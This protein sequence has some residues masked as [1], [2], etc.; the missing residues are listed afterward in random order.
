MGPSYHEAFLT[1]M[2]SLRK[3]THTLTLMKYL[4]AKYLFMQ[5]LISDGFKRHLD[6]WTQKF[7]IY[8]ASKGVSDLWDDF[9]EMLNNGAE[10]FKP[11][12]ILKKQHRLPWVSNNIKRL[13]RQR[14]KAFSTMKDS[15]TQENIDK[16]KYLKSTV[17]REI[18]K[19]YN[20]YIEDLIEPNL[21]KGNKKLW[22]M[23]KRIK[24]DSSGVGP[25]KK[26]ETLSLTHL[27][28]QIS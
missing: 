14:D 7:I 19:K 13:I 25:L 23:V 12:K 3:L 16:F 4:G 2:S 18:R 17:Q 22:G 28:K 24:R 6:S 21:D 20:K 11:S 5:R 9:K 8:K 26:M 27:V 10:K 1:M 15:S